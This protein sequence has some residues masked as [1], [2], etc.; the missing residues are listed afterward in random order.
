MPKVASAKVAMAQINPDVDVQASQLRVDAAWLAAQVPAHDVVIDC[1]DNFTTRQVINLACVEA[2]KP[3]VF[4]AAIQ[5]AGQLSVFDTRR[6]DSPCYACV[7]PPSEAPEEV[8]CAS[9]GVFA[10]LVGIV[11]SLQA[12]EAIQVLLGDSKLV[13]QLLMVQAQGSEFHR[14][15]IKRNPN[16]PVCSHPAHSAA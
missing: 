8:S 2:R 16:C 12:S 5:L 14:M 1:T 11:G 3:L 6:A 13:G 15:G 7:F 9:M 4:G 10:P